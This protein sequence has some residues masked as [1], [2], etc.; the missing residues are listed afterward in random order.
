MYLAIPNK[1]SRIK[2][3]EVFGRL[4]RVCSLSDHT[5]GNVASESILVG[6]DDFISKLYSSVFVCLGRFSSLL[7]VISKDNRSYPRGSR[8]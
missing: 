4:E 6:R 7:F 3:I 8:G 5:N 2:V 1:C